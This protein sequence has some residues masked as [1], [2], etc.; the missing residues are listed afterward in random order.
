MLFLCDFR[1]S[2]VYQSV[3]LG[4]HTQRQEVMRGLLL[5][6]SDRHAPVLLPTPRLQDVNSYKAVRKSFSL[7]PLGYTL[8][9]SWIP[10]SVFVKTV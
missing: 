8:D 3:L 9:S 1:A 4:L 5:V 2:G 7:L 10:A 6:S